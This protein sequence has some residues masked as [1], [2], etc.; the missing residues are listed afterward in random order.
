MTESDRGFKGVWIPKTVWLDTRLN[1]LEKVILAEIDSLDSSERGCWASNKHIADFCQCSE[2]KVST[3]ISKL[4]EYGYLY[5]QKFDGRQ[6]ELKSRLSNFERQ[7]AEN[8]K[9]EFKNLKESNTSSK[10]VIN[11]DSIKYIVDYLNAKAG[12][13]Y[14]AKSKDTAKHI[15]ARLAEGFKVEDFKTVIDKKCAEW[16][17]TEFEQ[18]LRPAT[19]FGTKFEGYLN[20]PVRANAQRTYGA[21]GIAIE[22]KPSELDGIL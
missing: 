2:T 1:A 12:K 8:C 16:L 13:N 20:A 6:R 7:N 22:N 4:I 11:T 15:N 14:R 21:N 18:Y 19:L 3:A 5:V 17:G 9:P 10:S